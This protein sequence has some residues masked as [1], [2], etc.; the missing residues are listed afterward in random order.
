MATDVRAGAHHDV[1]R[2]N[3]RR[4]VA[5]LVAN[6]SLLAVVGGLLGL[7]VSGV[8]GAVVGAAALLAAGG[9]SAL[10]APSTVTRLT[11]A[12][13]A[14]R[15][16]VPELFDA[17]DDVCLA[18]G[19]SPAPAVYV[20]VDPAPNAFAVGHRPD[21]SSVAVTTGLLDRLSPRELRA[22]LAHEVAHVQNRDTQ[23]MT[24][25]VG[26]VGILAVVGD[27]AARWGIVSGTSSR[28]SSSSSSG[29]SGDA[30]AALLV[31]T[32]V[33]AV[34]APLAAR[35]LVAAMSRHREEL[36]DAT[37]VDTLRDPDGLRR[38][39]EKLEADS[40]VV[41]ARSRATAFMWVESPLDRTGGSKADH[42]F[43]TH[44]PIAERIGVLRQLC[45]M[46]PAARGPVDPEPR[47]AAAG[48]AGAAAAG[49]Y[50]D[51]WRQAARRWWDGTAWTGHTA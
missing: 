27:L 42:L 46:D 5:L 20:V 35:L 4:S 30:A 8:P 43:D 38:A 2:R 12:A 23:L 50:P 33:V 51:P 36:A 17:L 25:A 9:L 3:R 26:T 44:P 10:S 31:V 32:V 19:M 39:L 21:R 24:M 15:E 22:V 47:P 16:D 48:V 37:A 28:R 40:T 7:Y 11:R 49:W 14:R 1:V 45:G 41:R 13:P 34:L 6:E 18:A 29:G